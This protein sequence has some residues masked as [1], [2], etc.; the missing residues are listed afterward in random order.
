MGD[1]A[2]LR[3]DVPPIERFTIDT[4]QSAAR[5]EAIVEHEPGLDPFIGL[6]A[7]RERQTWIAA[8]EAGGWLVAGVPE[9][10]YL[11]PADSDAP[12][13][14]RAWATAV[15]AC[16]EAK[17]GELQAVEELF[18]QSEASTE[19]CGSEGAVTVGSVGPVAAG[20]DSADLVAQYSTDVLQWARVVEVTGPTSPFSVVVAP[21]GDSWLVLGLAE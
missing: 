8:K 15:Q 5:V 3:S 1:W 17:A 18:G 13:A 2:E 12:P 14:V 7:A 20:P 21:I 4:S 11:L 19:L 16:D 10:E 9:V 6:S